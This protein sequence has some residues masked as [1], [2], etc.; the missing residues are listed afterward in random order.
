MVKVPWARRFRLQQY[1]RGSL[2]IVPLVG[3]VLGSV[4]AV[5]ISSLEGT[6]NP[7]EPLTYSASTA[8]GL[9]TA[10]VSAMVAFTGFVVT[11]SVLVIQMATGTFSARYM[12][13]WYRDRLQKAV[14][15]VI[16]GTLSFSLVT[17]RRSGTGITPN[18]GVLVAGIA[19]VTS[20]VLFLLFLDRF[21]HRLRPVH[22]AQLLVRDGIRHLSSPVVS[23]GQELAGEVPSGIDP[24]IVIRGERTGSIQALDRKGLLTWATSN[25]CLVVLRRTPGDF[26]S[27]GSP[28]A[29]VYADTPPRDPEL[30]LTMF[31]L[32]IE[33]TIEQDPAFAIRV[34]VDVATRALSP[35]V[36]DPTTAVQVLDH[37]EVLLHEI[38]TRELSRRAILRDDD[39][40]ARVVI[41]TLNWTDFLT[42]SV[43]EIRQYGASSIQVLR[44]LRSLLEDLIDLVLPD[45]VP[46][47]EEELRRLDA[48][49]QSAFANTVDMDYALMA[50]RQGI[51][52][53]TERCPFPVDGQPVRSG[54]RGSH[55]AA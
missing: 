2:W 7:P 14:L 41:P 45:H 24:V 50:D 12:R 17:L 9:L 30:L 26:V 44:R 34:L 8:S 5:V 27:K 15:A 10:I 55:N 54:T 18:L 53:P 42:L 48:T 37:L 1:V 11:I 49:A 23:T 43:T 4:L 13:L 40:R 33:R 32:G 28:I 19:V 20:I 52:G 22:V 51:G 36:N 29:D 46:A 47:I 3:G 16:L 39:G 25:N 6:L 31:A 21:I 38:G 35:A